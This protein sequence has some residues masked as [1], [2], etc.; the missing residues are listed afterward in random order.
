VV[1]PETKKPKQELEDDQNGSATQVDD[2]VVFEDAPIPIDPALSSASFGDPLVQDAVTT[3]QDPLNSVKQEASAANSSA[4]SPDVATQSAVLAASA[5]LHVVN[6][7]EAEAEARKN[8]SD[9][10]P[11]DA[12]NHDQNGDRQTPCHLSISFA[13]PPDQKS[14]KNPSNLT[15]GD[16]ATSV[17]PF[18]AS[19]PNS[20]EDDVEV[21]P[22]ATENSTLEIQT[23]KSNSR[24]SSRQPKQVDR[25]VPEQPRTTK[26]SKSSP[27]DRRL[28]SS[29][30]GSTAIA[31]DTSAFPN[32]KQPSPGTGRTSR[33]GS[34]I[35]SAP[36]TSPSLTTK[37]LSP[38]AVP[39][40]ERKS[41]SGSFGEIDADP[42]SLKLIRELQEQEF[43]LRRR[44]GRA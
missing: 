19:P 23:P 33:R 34:S 1:E 35:L 29:T 6:K 40:Q 4:L 41:Q 37:S 38:N 39:R 11:P 28:S 21:S 22:T 27:A 26:A 12:H 31:A 16:K 24:H 32:L 10:H 9:F 20:H 14:D 13:F 3:T 8:D 36:K 15:N 44:G 25:Y 7:V 2:S 18:L 30:T 42:E 5:A 17:G 43:G